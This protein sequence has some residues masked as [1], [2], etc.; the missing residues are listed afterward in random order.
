M[1]ELSAEFQPGLNVAVKGRVLPLFA[2]ESVY[3]VFVVGIRALSVE[4]EVFDFA[5]PVVALTFHGVPPAYVPV[6]ACFSGGVSAVSVGVTKCT[7]E[8]TEAVA[9]QHVDD[10]WNEM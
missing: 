8:V 4:C 6:V 10:V 7:V 1:C 3:E 9:K 2:K 5:F